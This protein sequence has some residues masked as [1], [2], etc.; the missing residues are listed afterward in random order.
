MKTLVVELDPPLSE[1]APDMST[2]DA[3]FP[4]TDSFTI[5]PFIED[6]ANISRTPLSSESL[7][8]SRF[9][10]V[11]KH[12]DIMACYDMSVKEFECS[13]VHDLFKVFFLVHNNL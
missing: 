13:T 9:K 8:W 1:V 11:V 10:K 7:A 2:P 3:S 12:E 5:P 4:T 6:P